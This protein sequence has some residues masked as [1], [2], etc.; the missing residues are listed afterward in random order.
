M[1]LITAPPSGHRICGRCRRP[2]DE[3]TIMRAMWLQITVW[4]KKAWT[5]NSGAGRRQ[6]YLPLIGTL[7]AQGLT[8][9][10]LQAEIKTKL[11]T[12]IPDASVT[13]MVKAPLAI[14]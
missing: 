5:G 12:L 10:A 9:N 11:A 6:H 3:F 1:F 14:R 4:K 13:V 2:A 7:Q 8:P